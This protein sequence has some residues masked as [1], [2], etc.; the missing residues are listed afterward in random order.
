MP[1][2]TDTKIRQALR[3]VIG[4]E[5]ETL[6]DVRAAVNTD[7]VKAVRLMAACKGKIVVTGTGKSGLIANKIAATLASTGTPALYLHPTDGLHGSLGTL[8]R[9]DLVLAIGKSGESSELNEILP[10]LK[11]LRVSYIAMTSK[12]RSTL[13]KNAAAVIY[14]P[15]KKEACPLNLAPTCSTTASLAVGDA[16]A[17]ALMKLRGFKTENFALLHPGGLIGRRLTL[18]VGDVMH[19][20]KSNPTIPADATIAKMLL[21]LT[22]HHTGAVSVVGPT[23]TLLGL[24]TDFDL[25]R[26]L[27]KGEDLR[28]K[29][30][31]QLMNKNPTTVHPETLVVDALHSMLN[32]SKPFAV[33]PVVDARKKA[34]GMIHLHDIRKFGL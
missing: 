10:A 17:V 26:V 16:I 12:R 9:Q 5:A 3:S 15:I 13:A 20:G 31:R 28:R 29:K 21:E 8:Q 32:R 18:T 1:N 22:R 7:Y 4:M 27:S 2:S 30:V 14:V 24:I 33:L 11:R 25:R 23:G 34:V 19:S 6:K